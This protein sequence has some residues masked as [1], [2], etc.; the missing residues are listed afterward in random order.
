MVSGALATTLAASPKT[1]TVTF[2][3][4]PA[5][6]AFYA[7][8]AQTFMGYTPIALK[9]EATQEFASGQGC[10]LLQA[11]KAR[12]ASG[13]EVTVPTIQACPK[14][15]TKQQLMI[16]RPDVPGREIDM[17]MALQIQQLQ[18]LKEQ[19]HRARVQ[20]IIRAFAPPPALNCISNVW[21]STVY[22]TCR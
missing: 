17:Q 16:V 5:G 3:S 4:E 13:A 8:T 20:E 15:G 6:A 2:Y 10:Q 9:Y 18:L 12:W 19:Q 21:G 11:G 1:F 14:N 7:N 22:T